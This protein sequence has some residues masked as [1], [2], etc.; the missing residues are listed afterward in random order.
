MFGM[1]IQSPGHGFGRGFGYETMA[2]GTLTPLE[3][4]KCNASICYAV[5]KE[6]H[7]LFLALQQAINTLSSAGG[8]KPLV[9]DGFI[10]S[11][12][13]SALQVLTKIG[14]TET[15]ATK[16]DVA[17]NAVAVIQ[18]VQNLAAVRQSAGQ[19]LSP[20]GTPTP[21]AAAAAA[22]AISPVQATAVSPTAAAAALPQ[23]KSKKTFWLIA[24]GLAAVL[25]VGV[26]GY[27][28]YRRKARG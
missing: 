15:F 21:T 26:G 8:F 3:D 14:L 16:E 18:L 1:L 11:S 4:F 27:V 22:G 10:G 12:T 17:K 20:P 28:V 23:A 9:V 6:N 25:A 13:V 19:K 5:G 2:A 7:A 24:G